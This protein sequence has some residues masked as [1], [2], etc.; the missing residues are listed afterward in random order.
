MG[1]GSQAADCLTLEFVGGPLDGELCV[2][3]KPLERTIWLAR[4]K[5]KQTSIFT[6]ETVE[7][8]PA[9]A[10][11]WHVYGIACFN[12][13]DGF[14]DIVYHHLGIEQGEL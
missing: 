9:D 1:K 10:G 7:E 13:P 4:S 8:L 6:I 2:F 11:H 5:D 12:H 14:C 3:S